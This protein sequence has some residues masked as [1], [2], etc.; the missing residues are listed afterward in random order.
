MLTILCVAT[1]FKGE[2]FLRECHRLGCRVL[3]LTSETLANAEWP[4]DAIAEIHIIVRNAPEADVRRAVAGI[5]RRHSIARVAALDDF[6][7]E[8]GAMIREFLQLPGIGRTIAARFRD[9]LAM[10]TEAQRL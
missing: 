7:V 8:L 6:D 1:Y 9:K 5:A 4:R 2:A 3:L 10:R